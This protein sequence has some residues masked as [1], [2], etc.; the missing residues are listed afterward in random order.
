ML[1]AY[2]FSKYR[3][4][5]ILKIRRE[6]RLSELPAFNFISNY[7][8][9]AHNT[10]L[11]SFFLFFY[12]AQTF[13]INC[14]YIFQYPPC[15]AFDKIAK[16]ALE[17]LALQYVPLPRRQNLHRSAISRVAQRK[18]ARTQKEHV[19]CMNRFLG[20]RPEMKKKNEIAKKHISGGI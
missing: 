7:N 19:W 18:S 13:E 9:I 1:F 6:K 20:G 12:P 3:Y 14:T 11:S 8:A 2:K 10:L 16:R 15:A 5:K 4:N 17:P